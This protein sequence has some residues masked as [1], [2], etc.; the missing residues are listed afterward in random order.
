MIYKTALK[1]KKMFRLKIYFFLNMP[2]KKCPSV[3]EISLF[4]SVIKV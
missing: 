1:E 3:R 4:L 2:E